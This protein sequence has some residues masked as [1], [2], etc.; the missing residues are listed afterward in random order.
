M[1]ADIV[2]Q[3]GE[4]ITVNER[5][6]VCEAVAV[7]GNRIVAV[8]SDKEMSDWIGPDTEVVNLGGKT[9][10]PGIIDAHLHFVLY[11]LNQMNISCKQPEMDSVANVLKALQKRASETPAGEW[12]RAWG[13]NESAVSEERYPTREELDAVS[14]EHPIIIARTCSHIG[15]ANSK[16][17]ELAGIEAETP[18]PPGGIIERNPDGSLTGRLIENAYMAFNAAARYSTEE[19]AQ[20]MQLAQQQFFEKG[21]TSVHEA[22]A[23]DE[24]SYRMMQLASGDGDLKL[25]IYAMIGTLNDC[26][27][28]TLNMMESGVVTGTGNDRFKIGPAKLF[29]DGSSTGPT[30]ATREGYT[31]DPDDHGILVYSD[32]EVYEVLGEAHRRGYQLTVHAQ[33]DRAVEQY[34]DVIERA[35][36]E[37]PRKHRHRIEHAGVT[38]PDLQKRMKELGV[39]PIP[40]PPFPYEFGETYFQ[41]Y[42]ERTEFMYPARDFLDLGIPCAAGSDAPVTTVEPMIG[43][44]TAVNRKT[45]A[46]N[47]FGIRQ[48]VSLLEAIRM[49][50]YNAAYASFDEQKKGSL[51]A[52]KLADLIVLDRAIL[53]EPAHR[54]KEARVEMTMID[55]EKVFERKP[56]AVKG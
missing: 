16:A 50:T 33:G 19:L 2:F 47:D 17:L 30:I 7:A 36:K 14:A 1:K 29:L 38:P 44:H 12:V 52:G 31:S 24:E 56:S 42:G 9:L 23:F 32:D 54:I 5:D 39:I 20:A 21:I 55:G 40:N 34:L 35:L 3:N 51:E 53:K 37:H 43:L 26:R 11:G 13:F 8:G 25:R 28:F 15:I 18:D 4:V 48:R 46:G 10:M 22:G 41:H 49:Y 6:E 45:A 27:T